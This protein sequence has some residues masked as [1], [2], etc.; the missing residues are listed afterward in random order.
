[1]SSSHCQFPKSCQTL[2]E[3]LK[4][5]TRHAFDIVVMCENFGNIHFRNLDIQFKMSV[6]GV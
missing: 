1:M 3:Q 6:V 5:D 2:D 4:F